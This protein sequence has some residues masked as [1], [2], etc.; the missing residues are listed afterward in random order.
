MRFWNYILLFICRLLRIMSKGSKDQSCISLLPRLQVLIIDWFI[1]FVNQTYVGADL[2]TIWCN[3]S[4]M[5]KKCTNTQAQWPWGPIDITT[6]FKIVQTVCDLD[7]LLQMDTFVN[8]LKTGVRNVAHTVKNVPS[9]LVDGVTM[10]S[11]KM[12]DTMNDISKVVFSTP[13]KVSRLCYCVS[14]LH[15]H[16]K[17]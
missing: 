7:F 5:E 9:N 8:P 12:T 17:I 10:V 1:M 2:G 11:D 13:G 6:N 15:N 4:H 14:K 3:W 16:W